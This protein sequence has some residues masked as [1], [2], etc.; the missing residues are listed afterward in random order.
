MI[1]R[2]KMNFDCKLVNAYMPNPCNTSTF[3]GF[4]IVTLREFND[5]E[6]GTILQEVKTAEDFLDTDEWAID[7]PFYRVF[8]VYKRELT[9]TRRALGDLYNVKDAMSLISDL[10]GESCNIYSI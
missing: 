8:G 2:E 5:Y 7:E 4:E 3:S 10:T 1:E 9:K 6:G